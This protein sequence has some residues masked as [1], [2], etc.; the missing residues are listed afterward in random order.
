MLKPAR[1]AQTQLA[2]QPDSLAAPAGEPDFLTGLRQLRA[3]LVACL[4][5]G[6]VLTH[7]L[8]QEVYSAQL[9]SLHNVDQV[10]A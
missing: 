5:L 9:C 4:D 6:V 2:V 1:S 8:L 10:H 3:R 7:L